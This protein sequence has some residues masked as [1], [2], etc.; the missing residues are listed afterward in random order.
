MRSAR[1]DLFAQGHVSCMN[2]VPYRFTSTLEVHEVYWFKQSRLYYMGLRNPTHA[3]RDQEEYQNGPCSSEKNARQHEQGRSSAPRSVQPYNKN[4]RFIRYK[5]FMR[6]QQQTMLSLVCA[7]KSLRVHFA[8]PGFA[9]TATHQFLQLST[10]PNLVKGSKSGLQGDALFFLG[11][12]QDPA[13]ATLSRLGR[14]VLA[15]HKPYK[16]LRAYE[17]TVA[18]SVIGRTRCG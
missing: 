16:F 18:G 11:Q 2:V 10:R 9:D 4:A 17:Q 8:C 3:T 6:Q 15:S 1:P 12:H 14:L 7:K 5:L 13:Q